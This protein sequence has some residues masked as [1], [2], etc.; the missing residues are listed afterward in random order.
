V[1]SLVGVVVRLP[2]DDP[3]SIAASFS[4]IRP[5]SSWRT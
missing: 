4:R 3:L 1:T 5:A 2:T